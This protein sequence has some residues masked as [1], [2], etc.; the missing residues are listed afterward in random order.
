[1]HYPSPS[2]MSDV[3]NPGIHFS[4]KMASRK[5]VGYDSGEDSDSTENVLHKRRQ[6]E[7]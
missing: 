4:V 1:M 3:I 7:V 2:Y 5:L 6:S